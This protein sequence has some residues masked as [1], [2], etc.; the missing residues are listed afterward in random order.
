M[1]LVVCFMLVNC[2]LLFAEWNCQGFVVVVVVVCFLQPILLQ[3]CVILAT[4]FS[5]L[6]LA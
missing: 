6:W 3:N 2:D 4:Y 1:T 5:R